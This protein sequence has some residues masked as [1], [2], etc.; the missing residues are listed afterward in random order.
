MYL[1]GVHLQIIKVLLSEMVVGGRDLSR[2][3]ALGSYEDLLDAG[4][5][6]L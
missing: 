1:F 4:R 6:D 2:Q 3:H 5:H